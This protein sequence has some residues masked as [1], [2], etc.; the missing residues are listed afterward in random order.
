MVS[1][2]EA[3]EQPFMQTAALELLLLSLAGGLLGSWIV[4]RRLAFF[5]HAAGTATF[6]GLVVADAAAISP[7]L[8]GL[9][10]A[11]GYAGGLERLRGRGDDDSFTGLL[12]VASVAAGVVLA[13]DLLGAGQSADRL[14]FGTLIGLTDA[15]LWWS[16]AAAAAAGAAT[17]ALGRAW[18]AAAFDPA[19]SGALGLPQRALELALL[20]LVAVCIVTALPA[21]G[22][23]LAGALFV[24]PAAT[25][26]LFARSVPT[27]LAG[28]VVLAAL[29][30][31]TGLYLAYALD[32]SPGPAVAVVGAAGFALAALGGRALSGERRRP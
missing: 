26:R 16:A 32:V 15:D 7:Q 22:A 31:V 3:F 2:L 27:L 30:G 13:S 1:P 14:L 12:L 4:L 29:E 20:G 9:A 25:V 28:S 10:V 17:L 21:V 18:A 23:L 5:T 6:P 8:A 19:G 24:V 11:L